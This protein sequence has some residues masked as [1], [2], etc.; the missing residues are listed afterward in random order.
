MASRKPKSFIVERVRGIE[1]PSQP[2]EGRVLPL[3]HARTFLIGL[4]ILEIHTFFLR[5]ILFRGRSRLTALIIEWRSLRARFLTGLSRNY[6]FSCSFSVV[7]KLTTFSPCFFKSKSSRPA[8][9]KYSLVL[10]SETFIKKLF[11]SNSNF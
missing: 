6:F 1:P 3:N 11:F 4:T 2:W 9:S 8:F 5:A 10:I 7:G